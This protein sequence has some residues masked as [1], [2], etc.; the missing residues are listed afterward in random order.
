MAEA[1]AAGPNPALGSRPRIRVGLIVNPIAGLGGRVGLHGSD[2]PH[3][4][5]RAAALGA[6]PEA[7]QKASETLR[8]MVSSW[9]HRGVPPLFMVAP[10]PMGEEAALEAGLSRAAPDHGDLDQSGMGFVVVTGVLPARTSGQDTARMAASLA[11]APVDLLL[12][13]GGDG[14]ARDVQVAIGDSSP[15]LGIPAGVKIQSSAFATSPTAAGRIAAGW[16]ASVRRR[17]VEREVLDLDEDAYRRGE[18]RPALFGYVRVPQDA[19]VQARKAP[20]PPDDAISMRGIAESVVETLD[21]RVRWVLGPGTTVRAIADRLAIAKTLVGIDVVEWKNGAASLAAE[22]AG[23]RQ[24][25]ALAGAGPL[26][27]IVT[28]IGGQGFLFGRGNQPI[29]PAVIRAAVGSELGGDHGGMERALRHAITIV[30]TPDKLA[31]LG[32]RPLLV[33]TGDRR[34]DAALAGP[35]TVI[36]GYQD[37]AVVVIA[38]A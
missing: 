4:P 11:A 20:T 27:I 5:E 16:L 22:D 18:V 15:V 10:G 2:G 26:Q 7:S 30:S 9:P 34:L 32:G 38:A 6:R 37:R 33:D 1:R 21:R 12:F 36:T 28:P 23:E 19:R 24:L 35:T 29:S 14:T 31:A 13:A 17:T 8:A 25:L 3:L